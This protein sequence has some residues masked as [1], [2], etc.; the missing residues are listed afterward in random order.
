MIDIV[1]LQLIICICYLCF[2]TCKFSLLLGYAKISQEEILTFIL[3]MLLSLL[4]F[5]NSYCS[6]IPVISVI[7]QLPFFLFK[8]IP[9]PSKETFPTL[10]VRPYIFRSTCSK[11]LYEKAILKNF[12]KS[13]KNKCARNIN[14]VPSLKHC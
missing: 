13:Q 3:W 6:A 5:V 12:S 7:W 14:K 11:V 8:A 1:L 9:S 4:Y 2:S 10:R